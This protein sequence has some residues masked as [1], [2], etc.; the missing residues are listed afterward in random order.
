MASRSVRSCRWVWRSA[1]GQVV[2]SSRKS[3]RMS[4]VLC[5]FF[6]AEGQDA[7]RVVDRGIPSNSFLLEEGMKTPRNE[8]P[9]GFGFVWLNREQ[10]YSLACGAGRSYSPA[11]CLVVTTAGPA[12]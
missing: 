2:A 7:Q 11:S 6:R 3:G 5:I 8:F 12:M 10:S 4:M 1:G 9:G